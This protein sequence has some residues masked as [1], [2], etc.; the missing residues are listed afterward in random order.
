MILQHLLLSLLLSQTWMFFAWMAYRKI[1][2]AMLADVVWGLGITSLAWFHGISLHKLHPLL[3]LYLGM[4]TVW[5]LRLSGYLFFTRLYLHKQDPRYQNLNQQ[6][7]SMFW[8]YQFQGILQNLIALP[9][10]FISLE[11]NAATFIGILGFML[12][13]ALE[14]SADY[15]LHR[16]KQEKRSGV[17]E[18]GLWQYSR[19][20]NYFGECLI[21]MSF[22]IIANHAWAW[23]SPISLYCIMRYL[24]GPMTEAQSIA[25]KG[26][27][28]LDYQTKVPMIFP[29]IWG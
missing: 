17:C 18:L 3:I 14:S 28:Y 15:Q 1:K 7:H 29:K 9:W 11:F 13:F 23:I 20:P 22:A 24:T 25:S 21:W 8:N 27:L 12:G 26:Q 5:G 10:L 2:N 16:F 19:H 4:V 6:G